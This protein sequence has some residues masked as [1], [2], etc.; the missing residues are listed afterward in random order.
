[1][2]LKSTSANRGIGILIHGSKGFFDALDCFL[3]WSFLF[4][5][6]SRRN[7]RRKPKPVRRHGGPARTDSLK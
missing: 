4:Q 2:P 1:M 6:L 5:P 3:S 7:Y